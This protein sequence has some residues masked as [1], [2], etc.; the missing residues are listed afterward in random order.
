MSG[1]RNG[2]EKR[3]L[4]AGIGISRATSAELEITSAVTPT[5]K[6]G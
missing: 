6:K 5:E 1:P 3:N 4:R 2:V